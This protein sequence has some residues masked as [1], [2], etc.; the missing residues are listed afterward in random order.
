[1]VD[2]II[3]LFEKAPLWGILALFLYQELRTVRKMKKDLNFAH[4]RIRDLLKEAKKAE[5][6][7]T[8]LQKKL[9]DLHGTDGFIELSN[10]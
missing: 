1:M 3:P 4:M 2:L 6:N 5:E 8:S 7:F 10:G 9:V